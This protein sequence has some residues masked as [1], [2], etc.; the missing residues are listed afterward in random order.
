M[1]TLYTFSISTYSE[2]VRW[3]LDFEGIPYREVRLLPGL[4]LKT[5]RRLAP[6]SSV[7]VID[8]N[9]TVVQ[10]SADIITYMERSLGAKRLKA[11]ESDASSCA[12]LESVADNQ[13]GTAMQTLG[14]NALLGDRKLVTRLWS[15]RGPWWAGAFYAV[16]YPAIAKAVR[17]LYCRTPQRLKAAE[18]DLMAGLKVTDAALEK[19]EY[20]TGSKPTRADLSLAALLAPLCRPAA[21]PVR[22]PP[23]PSALAE[24]VAP[25]LGGPTLSHVSRM[26]ALHRHSGAATAR[27]A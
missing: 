25:H 13:L 24:L 10:G 21:H 23:L 5:T 4:H 3:A 19:T 12:A 11:N 2:K 18:Q 17:K 15:D 27:S 8:H 20:L 6:G 22:W 9:G 1:L 16:T 26:Y 7:P 14:Y